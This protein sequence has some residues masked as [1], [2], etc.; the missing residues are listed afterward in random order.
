M[1]RVGE[2]SVRRRCELEFDSRAFCNGSTFLFLANGSRILHGMDK[3]LSLTDAT[4]CKL[5]VT[6]A[7]ENFSA[8]RGDRDA[9][10][11]LIRNLTP[12]T[13]FCARQNYFSDGAAHLFGQ[14]AR[15]LD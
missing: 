13:E 15:R 14:H 6:F 2:G 1:I 9:F 11:I 12:Q 5:R 3:V 7:Y 8:C 4:A 10:K